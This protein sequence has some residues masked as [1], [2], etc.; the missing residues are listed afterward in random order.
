MKFRP[1]I[2]LHDG[3]VK[4]IVGSSIG[5]NLVE[6]FVSTK[7]PEWY[8]DFF[9][10]DGFSGGHIIMLG[11]GNEKAALSA[12][13]TWPM[14]FHIGGGISPENSKRFLDA[15]ASHV[16]VT[17]YVFVDG[18][19]DLERLKEISQF[20]GKSRLVIDISCAL[21]DDDRYFVKT[22]KWTKWTDFEVNKENV[23]IL[24][25]YCS[26]ILVHAISVEGKQSGIDSGL[27]R[28]LS[29]VVDIPVTYAGGISS[30]EEI[31]EVKTVGKD[32]IDFTIGSAL[33]IFGGKMCYDEIVT[34][35]K[36]QK[37]G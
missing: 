3:K 16:I 14:G 7:S 10:K 34:L 20:V 29:E 1:C 2:D 32:K 24:S 36:N 37:E 8:A 23:R 19:F 33:D 15:G 5:G 17:S 28:L 21:K 35:L 27:L 12:L 30:I 18:K 11:K 4:Q 13:A 9:R 6:N 25:D 31:Q 22:D 26:E